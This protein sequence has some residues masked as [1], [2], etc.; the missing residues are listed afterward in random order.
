MEKDLVKKCRLVTGICIITG[1][2]A[3]MSLHRIM[4][5]SLTGI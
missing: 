4:W 2:Q 3:V 1:Q 5:S